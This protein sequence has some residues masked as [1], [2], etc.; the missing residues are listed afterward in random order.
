MLRELLHGTG[1]MVGAEPS[2]PEKDRVAKT[3]DYH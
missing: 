2:R 1:W 3:D